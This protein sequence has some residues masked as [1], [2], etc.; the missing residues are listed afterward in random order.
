MKIIKADGNTED[1]RP[2]KLISSLRGAGASQSEVQNIVHT[3]ES[4]LTEG[5]TTQHIYRR[6]F[7][8][9]RNSVDPVAAKYSMRRAIFALGPSGF[10]FE[11]YLGRVFQSEGYKTKQRL[12]IKGKCAVHEID[13]AG[14]SPEHSFVAEAKYHAQPGIKSD[15]QVA[16]Y[17][18]ARFLDLQSLQVCK[19]DVCGIVSL[20]VVTNTKFTLAATK[21]AE[22]AGINLLSWNYPKHNSLRDKIERSG[23]YPITVLTH[24]S[25]NQKQ[26]LLKQGTILCADIVRKP[27]LLHTL[28]LSNA[29]FDAVLREAS[30]LCG[31]K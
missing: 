19:D 16:M 31:S 20:Y 15:L 6:A 12:M 2:Q 1:F 25:N 13:V 14:Y 27:H 29:K 22:C 10:A 5:M 3:I 28:H 24:I 11:D 17:S 9:L 4:E 18:Y 23:L 7:E 26:T 30:A 21:Y 8:L